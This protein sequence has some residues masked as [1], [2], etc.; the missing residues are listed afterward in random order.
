LISRKEFIVA[1]TSTGRIL[2]WVVVVALGLV[3]IPAL[4][5]SICNTGEAC[6]WGGAGR[7][8]DFWDPSTSD[9][10]WPAFGSTGVANDDESI[11]NKELNSIR[12]FPGD[13]YTGGVNYC[14][15]PGVYESDIDGTLEN[16][17]QSHYIWG[18]ETNCGS[19]PTP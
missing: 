18:G 15:P 9:P 2:Q 5:D 4:A 10:D 1:R 8:G 11:E 13:A 19:D 3:S 7:T 17:G 6:I 12:V 14:V 16:D